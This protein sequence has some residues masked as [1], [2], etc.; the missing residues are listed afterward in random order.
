[1]NRTRLN[2][3]RR[4]LKDEE[5]RLE[6][7]RKRKVSYRALSIAIAYRVGRVEAYQGLIWF[8]A[9]Q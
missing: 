3:L 6:R 5:D 9:K 7:L 4:L 2:Y 8:L 1:M